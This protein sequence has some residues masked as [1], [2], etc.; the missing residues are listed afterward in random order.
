MTV[1]G[2]EQYIAHIEQQFGLKKLAGTDCIRYTLP[3]RM[4]RGF[5]EL[6]DTGEQFQVWITHAELN[7]DVGMS[8]AQDDNAYIG[9]SYVETD[10]RRENPAAGGTAN[11]LQTSR[12]TRSL[13]SDGIVQGICKANLPLHAVNVIVFRDFFHRYADRADTDIAFDIL[14]TIQSFDEQTFMHGLYPILAGMLHCPYKN[15]ARRLFMQSRVY[16]IAARLIALCDDE[17]AQ[18]VISLSPFDTKQIHTV[19]DILRRNMADP[20]SISALSRMVAMNEFKLKAGFKQVYNTTVYEYLRQ[21]RT[22]EA[23]E[24]MKEDL[25]LEQVAGKVGYKSLRGFTQAFSRCTGKTPAEWRKA[26]LK[27]HL[28]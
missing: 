22:E 5:F 8:Y 24:L 11:T 2:M 27:L 3:R 18:P 6:F 10:T 16:E 1:Y 13:P 21:L 17:R 14:K 7:Q 12:T 23:M 28:P 19:P 26:S 4:G 9:L 25:M 15:A 20:P